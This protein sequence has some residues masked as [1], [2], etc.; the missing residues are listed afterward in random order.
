MKKRNR[1]LI[2]SLTGVSGGSFTPT[3]AKGTRLRELWFE[4]SGD[5]A[6]GVTPD[7]SAIGQILIKQT[8]PNNN[9]QLV[10]AD[11]LAALM[12][13][14]NRRGGIV[15]TAYVE[16]GKCYASLCVLYAY[17]AGDR[18]NCI[19][20]QEGHGL[21][22]S[23]G[24]TGGGAA[25]WDSLTIEVY[26]VSADDQDTVQ[27]YVPVTTQREITLGGTKPIQ[28]ED[29][30]L[31]FT[32]TPGSTTAISSLQLLTGTKVEDEGSWE[33]LMRQGNSEYPIESSQRTLQSVLHGHFF[34]PV[35]VLEMVRSGTTLRIVGGTG[36]TQLFQRSCLLN[37][38]NTAESL[39][40]VK[41]IAQAKRAELR[42]GSE[43][44]SGMKQIMLPVIMPVSPSQMEAA[45]EAVITSSPIEQAAKTYAR[46]G[47]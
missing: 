27:L 25:V 20:F 12:L 28:M 6:A 43:L 41:G 14:Q 10:Q 23:V 21:S 8:G 46:I 15:D 47:G 45:V 42:D 24:S 17:E 29:N 2:G 16:G 26:A 13:Q 5:A 1:F 31:E 3:I 33:G 35:D 9:G 44:S 19:H 34:K 39:K 11:T 37:E 30:L 36:T 32:L 18:G 7:F 38:Q 4:F 40:E 22:I